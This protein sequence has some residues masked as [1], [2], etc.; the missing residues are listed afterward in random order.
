MPDPETRVW[1]D[2][3]AHLRKHSPG[4]CRQWFGEIE[5][6]GLS[7]GV[8]RLRARIRLAR[9][10]VLQTL[11]VG[12]GSLYLGEVQDIEATVLDGRPPQVSLA[13]SRGTVAALVAIQQAARSGQAVSLADLA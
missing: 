10:E 1:T 4:I 12:G 13:D 11:V 5:S 7:G 6:L 8:L 2:V 3:L 9:G